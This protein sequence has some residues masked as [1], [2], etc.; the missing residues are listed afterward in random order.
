MPHSYM[1]CM[2]VMTWLKQIIRCLITSMTRI[3]ILCTNARG[4]VVPTTVELKT[5]VH[6]AIDC[7]VAASKG[8]SGSH[9]QAVTCI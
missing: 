8:V 1:W 9:L 5:R 4:F 7:Q 3:C 6:I 2:S